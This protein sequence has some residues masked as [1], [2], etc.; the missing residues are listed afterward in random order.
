VTRR[1]RFLVSLLAVVSAIAIW[2]EH[3]FATGSERTRMIV[4][5][6]AGGQLVCPPGFV[7]QSDP[8]LLPEVPPGVL[9]PAESSPLPF[10]CVAPAEISV[11]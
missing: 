4:R 6:Q 8:R 5:R 3:G 2:S 1:E 11:R 10:A 9:S 7:Q